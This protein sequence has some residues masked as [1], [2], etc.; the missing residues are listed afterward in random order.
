MSE[1]I[2]TKIRDEFD[3][4]LKL[5][6]FSNVGYDIFTKWYVD[7]RLNYHVLIDETAPKKGIQELRY[8]DP[9]KIRKVREFKKEK[10]GTNNNP[11]FVKKVKNEYYIYNEK[12][13]NNKYSPNQAASYEGPTATGL[14]IANDSIVN[15]N[16]GLLNEKNTLVLSHLHKAYKPLNQ[17]RMMEDAV[18]IYRISRAPERRVFYLSLI[19][20]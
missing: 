4:V 14:K 12:G 15:C 6:D 8:V 3:E 17:L 10:V 1:G 5:L 9:R 13:F 20:I 7:G 18:V 16:S 19:H 2:K 11:G